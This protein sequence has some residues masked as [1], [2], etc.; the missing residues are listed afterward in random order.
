M[1]WIIVYANYIF[2]LFAF[3]FAHSKDD[4]ECGSDLTTNGLIFNTPFLYALLNSSFSYII[5]SNSTSSSCLHLC[6]SFVL[7]FP[8]LFSIIFQWHFL[9]S[10]CY[11]LQN[12]ENAYNF[13]Q[14]TQFAYDNYPF[15][16]SLNIPPFAFIFLPTHHLLINAKSSKLIWPI[17]TSLFVSCFAMWNTSCH[18]YEWMS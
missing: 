14:Q 8:L 18:H 3:L 13:Q 1:S 7:P 4:D 6:H 15:F 9:H 12:F 2:S 16:S 11:E 5:F 10:C 17:T